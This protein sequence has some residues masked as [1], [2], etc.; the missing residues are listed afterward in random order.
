MSDLFENHIV[1]CFHDTSHIEAHSLFIFSEK[2]F[3]CTYEN[4]T[5]ACVDD[6][7]L[8]KHIQLNHTH[9]VNVHVLCKTSICKTRN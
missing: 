2:K 3:K 7:G 9:K 4:C 5:Y 6:V 1:D 8:Q